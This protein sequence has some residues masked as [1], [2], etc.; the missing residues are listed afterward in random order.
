[1]NTETGDI[2]RGQAAI[3]AAIGRGEPVVPVSERVAQLVDAGRRVEA[4]GM[5][6]G[7]ARRRL[8]EL[9]LH[10]AKS[11]DVERVGHP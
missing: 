3:D 4:Q 5:T 10:T 2:Y 8:R 9:G 6:R 11:K 7:Q 1:M